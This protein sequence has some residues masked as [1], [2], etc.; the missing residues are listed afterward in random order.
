VTH[1][2]VKSVSEDF[3]R[4]K[5]NV[6]VAKLMTLTT[7][8]QRAVDAGAPASDVRAAAEALV[9]MLAPM[10]P[11]VAEELWR[12]PLRHEPSVHLA[13][14]PSYDEAL[15]RPEEV[16]LVVQVDG[17]IRD[18]L[19]VAADLDEEAARTLA[20][21]SEKVRRHLEGRSVERVF[22]GAPRPGAPMLLNIVTRA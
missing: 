17:K 22:Q 11:H 9:L 20:L 12:G 18:R 2:T 8:L 13:A 19:T 6:S 7:E 1:R 10:A 5:F 16:V 3:T 14:W 4:F 21:G 15:A